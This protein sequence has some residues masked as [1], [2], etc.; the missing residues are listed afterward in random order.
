M[1]RLLGR[2]LSAIIHMTIPGLATGI[3]DTQGAAKMVV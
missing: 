3:M 1:Y 2:Y